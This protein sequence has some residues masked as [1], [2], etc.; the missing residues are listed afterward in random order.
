[1][2]LREILTALLGCTHSIRSDTL[3]IKADDTNDVD[4]HGMALLVYEDI[5][6]ALYRTDG[7]EAALALR[8]RVLERYKRGRS[9]D[10]YREDLMGYTIWETAVERHQRLGPHPDWS[11]NPTPAVLVEP[12]Q[13]VATFEM[14][15]AKST[16][17]SRRPPTHPY[18]KP[19]AQS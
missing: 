17:R 2:V 10:N 8:E 3:F 6:M 1:M 15:S 16:T 13:R 11:R 12:P 5:Y 14:P 18:I 19:Q 9:L 4:E 7:H